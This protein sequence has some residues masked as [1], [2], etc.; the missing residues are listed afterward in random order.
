MAAPREN[1]DGLDSAAPGEPRKVY[2]ETSVWG[3]TL[4]NQ[5]R[6]LREPTMQ[7]LRQ[8]VSGSFQPFI[9]DVV[10][11]EI[12]H[13]PAAAAGRM[14]RE[15]EKVAPTVLQLGRQSKEL[16]EAYLQAGVIPAK[17]QDDARH[18]AVA[19]VAGLELVVSWN[20]RH[21]ANERKWALFNAVNRLAG[22]EQERT[23]VTPFA[24]TQ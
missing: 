7:F 5:P 12:A 8:C 23:I 17:K 15:I 13:A 16:A 10:L 6:A 9:S 21:L 18:V 11:E 4:G 3:M 1:K 2:I 24:V 22:Y 19:T 14:G 20:H